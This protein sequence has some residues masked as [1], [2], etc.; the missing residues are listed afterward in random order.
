MVPSITSETRTKS[1]E[2]I[3]KMSDIMTR[4]KSHRDGTGYAA[5]DS[6]GRLF[7]ERWL[8]FDDAFKSRQE[9]SDKDGQTIGKYQGFLKKE[10]VY[11]SFGE[12]NLDDIRSITLHTRLATSS[13]G[14]VNCHPFVENDTSVIHNGIIYNSALMR[15]GYS[16]CDSE[17]VLTSY[18]DN[19]VGS[20]FE[21][22]TKVGA[23]LTGYYALGIYSRDF[24]GRRTLDI[25]RSMSADLIAAQIEGVG[26]VFTSLQ[27]QLASACLEL[28]IT[29]ESIY[30]VERG[31]IVRIDPLTGEVS[32]TQDFLESVE[33]K[34]TTWYNDYNK[35]AVSKDTS[36]EVQW[37]KTKANVAQKRRKSSSSRAITSISDNY[38]DS[39]SNDLTANE[40]SVKEYEDMKKWVT[41]IAKK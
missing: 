31:A 16:T 6:E 15:Q 23:S 14:I 12:V 24:K 34:D 19:N 27:S 2:L 13:K 35:T 20:D 33:K 8:K 5:I 10:K 26:L 22:F 38:P 29:I 28:K 1:M 37:S 3:A 7:G 32:G 36:K 30:E 21:L 25:V 18:N 9:H 11:N 41:S 4:D 39:Y 17:A 40:S